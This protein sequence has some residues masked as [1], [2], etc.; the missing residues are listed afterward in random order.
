MKPSLIVH[1]GAWDIPDEAVEACKDGC[2]HALAAGW[3]ILSQDGPALDAV[4]AKRS[5]PSC[6]AE[7]VLSKVLATRT[8]CSSSLSPAFL[9]KS[10]TVSFICAAFWLTCS[11]ARVMSPAES[12]P[13]ESIFFI[14]FLCAEFMTA[15]PARRSPN[16][17]LPRRLSIVASGHPA[18]APVHGALHPSTS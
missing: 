8:R 3:S 10:A 1:G 18:N 5:P 6:S 12:R 15:C 13:C 17:A 11:V 2:E 4:E 7:A 16:L 14:P 9:P